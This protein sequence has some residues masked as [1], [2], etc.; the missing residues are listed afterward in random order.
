MRHTRY[1]IALGVILVHLRLNDRT[2]V[3]FASAD[4]PVHSCGTKDEHQEDGG[5]V[6]GLGRHGS[7]GGQDED[8]GD[9]EGPETGPGVDVW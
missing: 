4:V 9:K 5:V 8:D 7:D 6:H 1:L 3:K 2:V